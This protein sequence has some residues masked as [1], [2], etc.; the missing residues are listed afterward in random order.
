M[1][2]SEPVDHVGAAA[3]EI[4][5][6]LQRYCELQDA[7][8]FVGVSQLFA[9]ATYRVRNGPSVFGY[10]G[11]YDLKTAHDQ[12]HDD[13]TM[14]TKH[15]TT[16]TIFQSGVT[17]DVVHTRSYFTVFQAT[18]ELPLQAV[19]AGSY[20]DRFQR[21]VGQWQ[22]VDRLIVSDLI[23]DLSQHIAN[24]PIVDPPPPPGRSTG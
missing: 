4:G 24:N 8:D 11:V 12:T 14:R 22:F 5:S 19:I 7:A 13:G 1:T 21:S 20:L 10:R 17:P 2:G 3:V 23:G 15:V 18:P 9:H 6:L 16:N